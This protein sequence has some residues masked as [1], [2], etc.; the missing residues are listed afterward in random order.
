[1]TPKVTMIV[2]L[3]YGST[4]KGLIAGFLGTTNAYTAAVNANMPNAGHT[5]IDVH[6]RKMVHKVLPN[7]IV[8]RKVRHVFIGP[9]SV[10]DPARLQQE[11]DQAHAFGYDHF[12]VLIHPAAV[13]LTKEHVEKEQSLVGS[14][15]STA[16]GSM[17]ASVEKMWRSDSVTAGQLFELGK[18][19]FDPPIFIMTHEMYQAEIRGHANILAEAAQGFSLGINE[20]FYP[21]CTSRSCDPA[22]FMS[23]MGLPW[24]TL[25]HV[26]GTVRTFPIRVGGNSGG[27]YPDQEEL[28]W[29]DIGVEPET[30]TVTGRQRRIANISY[31]Q[32]A[33]A[34]YMCHPKSIFLNFC[35]YMQDPHDVDSMVDIIESVTGASVR[36]QGWGPRHQDIH[37]TGE[38]S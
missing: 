2:D 20:H 13:P 31:M 23:D 28:S 11:V 33:D 25:W 1:M 37:L 4:G 19:D 9:G 6:G 14:I 10:F 36:W 22:R 34:S 21:Y 30:T 18:L 27:W 38:L 24:N 7:A 17:V 15:G 8:G 3:Q 35:N 29:E 26:I 5:Y 32:L 12:D 16:Q